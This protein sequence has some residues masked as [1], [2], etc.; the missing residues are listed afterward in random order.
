MDHAKRNISTAG[1]AKRNRSTEN[2]V[3]INRVAESFVKRNKDTVGHAMRNRYTVSHAKRN[4]STLVMQRSGCIGRTKLPRTPDVVVQKN[5]AKACKTRPGTWEGECAKYYPALQSCKKRTDS[6]C[7]NCGNCLGTQSVGRLSDPDPNT[8][9][10]ILG[11][12][13]SV[14]VV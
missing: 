12:S 1:H 5:S 4:R 8:L 2:H 6:V 10:G 13:T 3:L 11:I 14:L 9:Q 7:A